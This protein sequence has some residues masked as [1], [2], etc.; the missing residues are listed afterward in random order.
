[1]AAVRRVLRRI[2]LCTP[3]VSPTL[4]AWSASGPGAGDD[5]ADD[6]YLLSRLPRRR[7]NLLRLLLADLSVEGSSPAARY[8]AGRLDPA[9]TIDLDLPGATNTGHRRFD[10]LAGTLLPQP[11]RSLLHVDAY[12]DD[13][14]M[15]VTLPPCPGGY[16]PAPR[17]DFR[18]GATTHWQA[19]CGHVPEGETTITVTKHQDRLRIACH[20]PALDAAEGVPTQGW[21]SFTLATAVSALSRRGVA[22]LLRFRAPTMP[23]DA[24]RFW[25]ELQRP[26][27]KSGLW[28]RAHVHRRAADGIVSYWAIFA[29]EMVET[30]R[31][32]TESGEVLGFITL[33]VT[34]GTVELFSYGVVEQAP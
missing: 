16:G 18:A 6:P 10:F 9:D 33:P 26:G 25:A 2:G 7:D 29:T 3:R 19:F 30:L 22:A 1:M 14:V 32:E 23:D 27:Y 21:G 28:P 11:A 12:A 17:I 5:D 31:D 4:A 24:P 15:Q 8:L 34:C 13:H 20:N